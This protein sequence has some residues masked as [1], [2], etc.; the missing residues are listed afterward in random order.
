MLSTTRKVLGTIVAIM[1]IIV[2]VPVLFV[3]PAEWI[4]FQPQPYIRALQ[5]QN[6]YENMPA[7]LA[8]EAVNNGNNGAGNSQSKI[9]AGLGQQGYQNI[10]SQLMPQNWIQSQ[11]NN[12]ITNLFDYLNFKQ[13]TLNLNVDLRQVKTRFSGAQGQAVSKAI[14]SSWPACSTAQLLA[15]I[16][17][18]SQGSNLANLPLCQPPQE[19]LPLAYQLVQVTLSGM[20]GTLPDQLNITSLAGISS[21]GD[22]TQSA[23]WQQTFQTYKLFR[24]GMQFSP[25]LSLV[26]LLFLA[27]ITFRSARTGWSWLG[28]TILITGV[29]GILIAVILY[30]TGDLIVQQLVTAVFGGLL[31]GLTDALIKAITEVFNRFYLWSAGVALIAS[32]LGLILFLISRLFPAPARSY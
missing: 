32:I 6:F 29:F 2:T 15:V 7:W 13:T 23:A 18:L 26:L 27:L 21:G 17:Q 11:T 31:G 8:G 19:Y 20:T 12:L 9:L 16:T 4:L 1:F 25:V 14:V 22:P 10:F 24:L 5:N 28:I 30:L 3:L